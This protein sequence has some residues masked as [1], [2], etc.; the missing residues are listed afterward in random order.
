MQ[1]RLVL[2]LSVRVIT[3][4][5]PGSL[6]T[7]FLATPRDSLHHT[8]L[9]CWLRERICLLFFFSHWAMVLVKQKENGKP[10]KQWG[11]TAWRTTQVP[12][13]ETAELKPPEAP[14]CCSKRKEMWSWA[15]CFASR[16]HK[17]QS[18]WWNWS[19]TGTA[20]SRRAG[21]FP[22]LDP[23]H[24]LAGAAAPMGGMLRQR[25]QHTGSSLLPAVEQGSRGNNSAPE[26]LR[27]FIKIHFAFLYKTVKTWIFEASNYRRQRKNNPDHIA[28]SPCI[29]AAS[30]MI[31]LEPDS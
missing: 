21:C 5:G 29:S 7:R 3:C 17:A 18:C 11:I 25:A 16:I 14:L 19:F 23:Q 10:T 15:L 27:S 13:Q 24:R 1:T 2:L 22:S 9:R 30:L 20:H 6:Q 26:N 12:N 28:S 31:F 8:R 4:R